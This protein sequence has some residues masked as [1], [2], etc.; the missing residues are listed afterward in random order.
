MSRID[1]SNNSVCPRC[2]QP[3]SCGAAGPRCDCFDLKLTPELRAKLAQQY[4]RCLCLTC[5]KQLQA[6]AARS[7]DSTA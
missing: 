1:A 3:F 2:A 4:D 6:E 5:L 7:G